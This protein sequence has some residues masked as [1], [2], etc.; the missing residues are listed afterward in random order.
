MICMQLT[1]KKYKILKTKNYFKKNN[2]IFFFN[3]IHR[4]ST[5]GII[6]EQNIKKFNLNYYKIYNKTSK[7]T[8]NNSVYINSNELINSM[9]VLVK[10]IY[11]SMELKKSKIYGCFKPLL[12]NM[13][14]VKFNNKIYSKCQLQELITF[15]YK[16]TKLL[17]HQFNI[18]NLKILLNNSIKKGI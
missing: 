3:S 8:L 5:N 18:T 12:F 11:K 2:L 14:A 6:I 9:T 4:N 1:S 16:D 17:F 7:L 10:P 13:L 15:N